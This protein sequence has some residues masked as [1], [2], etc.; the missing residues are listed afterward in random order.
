MAIVYNNLTSSKIHEI[1]DNN[2]PCNGVV[3]YQT[4]IAIK[5]A[6]ELALIKWKIDNSPLSDE[7]EHFYT[8]LTN[9]GFH[10]KD[11]RILWQM[12][13]TNS[14]TVTA[15]ADFVSAKLAL[16]TEKP[17]TIDQLDLNYFKLAKII[18]DNRRFHLFNQEPYPANGGL[19]GY[20]S[21]KIVIFADG[22]ADFIEGTQNKTLYINECHTFREKVYNEELELYEWVDSP[23][24]YPQYSEKFVLSD[25]EFFSFP[26]PTE[27]QELGDPVIKTYEWH[28]PTMPPITN[29]NF[30]KVVY[31][32]IKYGRIIY[33]GAII[34]FPPADTLNDTWFTYSEKSTKV[35]ESSS[36]MTD[37]LQRSMSRVEKTYTWKLNE[38]WYSWAQEEEFIDAEG[39]F[40]IN[41]SQIDRIED[42]ETYT[43]AFYHIDK[44]QTLVA[45]P[46][47]QELI[48]VPSTEDRRVSNLVAD[49]PHAD[50]L[51]VLDD[52]DFDF[53][54]TIK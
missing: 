54:A 13:K 20:S 5:L 16:W 40:V 48:W 39:E 23:W 18:G 17:V 7:L 34:T 45:D 43:R 47:T 35:I 53:N 46:E 36:M 51:T 21:T 52:L 26:D 3:L 8:G 1:L 32:I 50:Y 14:E 33:S 9:L 44:P 4:L 19:E 12:K 10:I 37:N 22:K 49:I 30:K 28:G 41:G 6:Q 42:L 25:E 15:L 2:Y 29:K 11:P 24:Q 27:Q 38:P 31:N